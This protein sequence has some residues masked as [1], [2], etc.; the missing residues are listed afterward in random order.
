M[1][2]AKKASSSDRALSTKTMCPYCG[3]GCGLEVFPPARKGRKI[4]RDCQG[5]PIWQAEGHTAHPSSKG[6]G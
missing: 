2:P 3:V 4:T 5:R 1:F 6:Q